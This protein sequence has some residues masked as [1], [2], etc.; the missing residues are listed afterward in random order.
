MDKYKGHALLPLSIQLAPP[1][2]SKSDYGSEPANDRAEAMSRV[3]SLGG[4]FME[5]QA[6]TDLPAEPDKPASKP[7]ER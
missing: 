5:D 2:T 3:E 4:S 1:V 7:P 6:E